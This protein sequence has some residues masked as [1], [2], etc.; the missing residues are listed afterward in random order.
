MLSLR[1]LRRTW[2]SAIFSTG[3]DPKGWS[4]TTRNQINENSL[5]KE[6]F[7]GGLPVVYWGRLRVI[8]GTANTAKVAGVLHGT[9]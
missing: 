3:D 9:A 4:T 7:L 2:P 8:I 6:N 1:F 5:V